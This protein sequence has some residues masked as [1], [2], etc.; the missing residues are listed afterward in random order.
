MPRPGI[1][2]GVVAIDCN[3]LDQL[4][5]FWTEL[6]G[7]GVTSR[8]PDWVN[9][10]P[11]SPGGPCLAF[12]LVPEGKAGKNR[13]HLDLWVDDMEA[14]IGR[15]EALGARRVGEIVQEGEGSFQV[16]AD[17]AGNEFCLVDYPW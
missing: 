4:V 17:P 12:Q 11:T 13:L 7:V 2:L 10:E 6:L 3:D 5:G 8:D 16:M 1:S 15:A 9:L 14:E